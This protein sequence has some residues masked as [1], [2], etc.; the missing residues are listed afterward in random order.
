MTSVEVYQNE[1]ITPTLLKL[2]QQTAEEGKFP[3]SFYES[4]I[5]LTP[6]PDK[7]ATKKRKL[8]A[9]VTENTDAKSSTKF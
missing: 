7:D 4:T 6:K 8:Q 9:N 2:F 5:T 1:E 3:S